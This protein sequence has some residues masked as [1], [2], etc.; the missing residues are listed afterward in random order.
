V[1]KKGR[2]KN[3]NWEGVFMLSVR[4][5]YKL[6]EKQN[7]NDIRSFLHQHTV[8]DINECSL[9]TP[10]QAQSIM[11]IAISCFNPQVMHCLLEE[12]GA[13]LNA[14]C[15]YDTED[16]EW[17]LLEMAY[18]AV[19][20]PTEAIEWLLDQG[21]SPFLCLKPRVV[22]TPLDPDAL[23]LVEC[24]ADRTRTAWAAHWALSQHPVW[25]DM[26]QQVAQAVVATP[27]REFSKRHK[28]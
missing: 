3:K 21:A 15:V 11:S 26:A 24:A 4:K 1:S 25:R 5:L 12:F 14:V 13:D 16:S 20:D 6:F 22:K 2:I 23:C 18:Y 7:V 19:F 8:A 27:V 9:L 10:H 17:Y 28:K